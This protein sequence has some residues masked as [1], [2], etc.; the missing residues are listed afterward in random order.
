M[1]QHLSYEQQ[2]IEKREALAGVFKH[3]G[4]FENVVI[5]PVI[6]SRKPFHYRNTVALSTRHQREKSYFGFIGHDNQSF[7]SIEECPIAE[8]R[9]N[10]LIPSA[11]QEFH[12]FPMEKRR[13]TSQVVIR[14]GEESQYTS[15]RKGLGGLLTAIVAG[16]TFR[17]AG[18]SFFQVNFSILEK[19]VTAI[20]NLLEPANDSELVDLYCGVGLFSL[21]LADRYTR[22]TGIEEGKESVQ[23]ARANAA[24]NK[25]TNAEF[26]VGRT[27]EVLSGFKQSK[28]ERLHVVVDPPRVGM[29]QEAIQ[30]LLQLESVEKV[31]YVSC[32]PATLVRDI[33]LLE[34]RFVISKVQP[35]DMFPQ[36]KHLETMVLLLPR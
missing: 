36:T 31:V 7:I 4:H 8:E 35:L 24:F 29:K 34:E 21:C 19:M 5:E 28:K 10:A 25:I 32:D 2:L 16:K 18:S 1:F 26:I 3:L 30:A 17:Y 20:W 23:M 33:R 9:L 11:L 14:I 15:L 27:E 13:R 6:P 12:Q 22:V